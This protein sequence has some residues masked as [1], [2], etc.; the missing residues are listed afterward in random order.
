VTR[1]LALLPLAL[2]AVVV[3]VAHATPSAG[4][5]DATY[6]ADGC[7]PRVAIPPAAGES[8]LAVAAA[9][10]VPANDIVLNVFRNGALLGSADTATSPEA[11]VAPALVP[12]AAASDVFEAQVC[13]FAGSG[14]AAPWTATGT[15]AFGSL[16]AL[17]S[18]Q[19]PPV[20]DGKKDV[21][22]HV[23]D[24]VLIPWGAPGA[25]ATVDFPA[26]DFNG[27]TLVLHDHPD[28][29]GFDRLLTVEV[30]GVELFRA[31]SP[32]VDYDVTWDVTPYLSLLSNGAHHVF[33]HEESYLGRGHEVTL[34]VVL[35]SANVT[36]PS[37][38]SYIA[39]PWDYAGLGPRSGGGCGGNLADVDPSYSA[40][41][42]DTRT[43]SLPGG[44]VVRSATFYGYLSAHGC[45][46]F[47]Y[48]TARPTPVRLVHL[49][50]DGT[51]FADFVPKPYTYA[52]IGGD[53]ND[54]TWNAVDGAVW[55]TVQPRL[56]EHGVYDGTG[57][58]PPYTFDVTSI[59][60]SLAPGAHS[61]NITIDNGDGTWVFSG[62]VLVSYGKGKPAR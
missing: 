20:S 30:D 47:W 27:A 31:T 41:I 44:D 54:P 23:L 42:D 55:N 61:L 46:E 48:S 3:P 25:G 19:T 24:D 28:G 50:I 15:Y 6:T 53:P 8:S 14:P 57:A 40:N 13:P 29:D 34:D 49:A 37:V 59:V 26:G 9:A 51:P 45:E 60:K 62:Q 39:A 4:T 58:I 10:T 17:P 56:A 11:Y 52:F 21:R 43:F 35:H 1:R 16:P 36:P 2:L 22:V 32:R 38:A 5:F 7:G 18:P 33:V 12:P